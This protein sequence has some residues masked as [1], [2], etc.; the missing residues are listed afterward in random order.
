MDKGIIEQFHDMFPMTRK[1]LTLLEKHLVEIKKC[2]A[3]WVEKSHL[4]ESKC[5]LNV[6]QYPV[7]YITFVEFEDTD[8]PWIN[9][10]Q[11][12]AKTL[13]R[14]KLPGGNDIVQRNLEAAKKHQE[15]SNKEFGSD[16]TDDE[17]EV[18][19]EH[20]KPKDKNASAYAR[21]VKRIRSK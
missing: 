21:S 7:K 10:E 5:Q 9:K 16:D 1:A 14:G 3:E 15:Q 19:Y 13:K 4:M 12:G 8:F 17:G 18:K 2:M 6:Q 20:G 11:D